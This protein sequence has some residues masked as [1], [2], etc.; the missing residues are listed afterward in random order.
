MINIIEFFKGLKKKSPPS[1]P[2]KPKIP[3]CSV[4]KGIGMRIHENAEF[5]DKEVWCECR[6]VDGKYP[7]NG[8]YITGDTPEAYHVIEHMGKLP[9]HED[10]FEPKLLVYFDD[11]YYEGVDIYKKRKGDWGGEIDWYPSFP[12]NIEDLYPSLR[13]KLLKKL[14]LNK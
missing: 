7:G 12:C 11:G 1:S 5:R 14:K 9:N 3:Q 4:C 2:T 6:K 13:E 8:W 10:I